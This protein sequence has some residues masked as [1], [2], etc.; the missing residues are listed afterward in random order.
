MKLNIPDFLPK[1]DTEGK[2]QSAHI[3]E[4]RQRMNLTKNE[5]LIKNSLVY[6]S[7]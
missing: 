2:E 7:R 1:T 6:A 4:V 5:V 3:K